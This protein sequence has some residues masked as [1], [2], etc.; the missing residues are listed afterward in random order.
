MRQLTILILTLSTLTSFG[1]DKDSVNYIFVEEPMP[2]YPGGLVEMKNFIKTN[3]NTQ[4][5]GGVVRERFL[6][7]LS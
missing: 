5:T 7:N 3:L 2:S 4:R 1:Q 6:L